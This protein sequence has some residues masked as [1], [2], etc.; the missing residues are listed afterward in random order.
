MKELRKLVGE[1][2][3]AVSEKITI[4][5]WYKKFRDIFSL[6]TDSSVND[7]IF[8]HSAPDEEDYA[9]NRCIAEEEV[10]ETVKKVAQTELLQKC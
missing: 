1:K 5:E 10:I 8:E 3:T 4:K 6:G 7:N 2:K 9:L